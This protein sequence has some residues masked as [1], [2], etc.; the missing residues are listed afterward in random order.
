MRLQV[1]S[2][3]CR[4]PDTYSF[5]SYSLHQCLV[6]RLKP[7]YVTSEDH[8][9]ASN[10][11]KNNEATRERERKKNLHVSLS[12]SLLEG[13]LAFGR[14]NESAFSDSI[15]SCFPRGCETSYSRSES[16]GAGTCSRPVMP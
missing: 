4:L 3:L 10:N 15:I 6:Q 8:C 16:S 7:T 12:A 5:P 2:P 11:P 13:S 9:P 14:R 1:G